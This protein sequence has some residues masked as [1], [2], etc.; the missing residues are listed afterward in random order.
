MSR[1]LAWGIAAGVAVLVLAAAVWAWQSTR[2]GAAPDSEST[3]TAAPVATPDT[4]AIAQRLLDDHLEDCT[5]EEV[6]G[7]AAPQGCGIR[8]PWGTE[9]ADVDGIRF[10][11]ERMPVLSLTDDGFVADDGVLVATVS[12]TGHDGAARVETYRTE[13][14]QLRGDLTVDGDEVDIDV[15]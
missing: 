12:G 1:R 14:W 9:F 11:I 13:S 3:T 6:T 7:D 10:R 15:W 4:Q 5:A 8:I 2:G